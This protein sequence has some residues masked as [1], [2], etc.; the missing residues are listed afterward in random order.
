MTRKLKIGILLNSF[1]ITSWEYIMLKKIVDGDYATIALTI[2][3]DDRSPKPSLLSK[4]F[5]K[6]RQLLYYIYAFIDKKLFTPKNNVF[7]LKNGEEIFQN[8]DS[9]AIQPIKKKYSDYYHDQDVEKIKTYELDVIL[10]L[11]HRILRGSILNT[12]KYGIWSLHHGDNKV[13]RGGPPGFWE[14]MLNEPVTGSILQI[15][16]E[17]LDGGKLLYKSH[18]STYK[19]SFIRNQNRLYWKT[20][21]FIPRLLKKLHSQG[22]EA[23][24]SDKLNPTLDF[25]SHNLF[26]I[27]TNRELFPLLISKLFQIIRT[28]ALSLY[29]RE[30]WM[31]LYQLKKNGKMATS[32]RSYKKIIPPKD[33]FWADPHV[34]YQDNKYYIYIEEF[35]YSKTK[36][37]ISVIT[38]DE[39]GNYTSP[40]K[41][42]EKPYHLSYPF[43]FEHNNEHYMI[44]E[45]GNNKTIELYQ[46][47]SFPN[48]WK[49]V[50]NLIEGIHAVDVTLLNHNNKWWLFCNAFENK[51]T[52]SWDELFIFYADSPL[53]ETW[54][55]HMQNPVVSDTRRAR[56]A[57]KIFE[58]HGK[59]IRPAQDCS[60]RYGYAIKFHEI[61]ELTTEKY[62][63]VEIDQIV[64]LWDKKIKGTHTFNH[65]SK[66]T[67]VDAVVHRHRIF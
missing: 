53:S 7:D 47:T 64:P 62:E 28:K 41:I 20:A 32:L 1:E 18:S 34:I 17:N 21:N 14:V 48:Q 30:Q 11:G 24:Y 33:R 58:H 35:I 54:T 59:I 9:I 2:M 23:L 12:A 19:Y 15:L 65:T 22:P 66:M 25:Y 45:T 43:V 13:N 4:L 51:S 60:K 61:I 5:T 63:E 52:P 8:V 49:F 27:P 46:C 50:K 31:L 56:P 42:L 37:H 6:R 26:R 3:Y 67:I 36:G 57:G 55:P 44:P 40:V 29:T 38:L 16:N 39:K 10:R